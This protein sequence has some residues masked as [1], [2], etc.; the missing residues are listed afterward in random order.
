[1][2]LAIR[3]GVVLMIGLCG[4][5]MALSENTIAAIWIIVYLTL[6][7]NAYASQELIESQTKYIEFLERK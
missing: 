6:Q 1:M 5:S 7:L 3:I 4:I 2:K